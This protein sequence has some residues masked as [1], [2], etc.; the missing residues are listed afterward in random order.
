MALIQ[1]YECER[2]ISDQAYACPHCGVPQETLL[3]NTDCPKCGLLENP[4][5]SLVCVSCG[6]PLGEDGSGISRPSPTKKGAYGGKMAGTHTDRYFWQEDQCPDCGTWLRGLEE[7]PAKCGWPP[8]DPKG[9]QLQQAK[10]HEGQS[11]D[12]FWII[13]L[14][15]LLLFA[16]GW[17]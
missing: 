3:T 17:C 6:Y 16:L 7:C 5:G 13:A 1:C 11:A 8:A 14:I 2:E 4:E 15:G 9:S 12:Q 10:Y